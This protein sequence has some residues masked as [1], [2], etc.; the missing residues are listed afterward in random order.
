[1]AASPQAGSP[2]LRAALRSVS[3][4]PRQTYA[5]SPTR[6]AA[7][8]SFLLPRS[9]LAGAKAK[10]VILNLIDCLFFRSRC[11]SN[12]TEGYGLIK[13]ANKG[14]QANPIY[15]ILILLFV[16]NF[17][18]TPIFA[19]EVYTKN[20]KGNTLY[21]NGKF[22]DA[23][24]Q[25]DDALLISP[26]DTLLKMNRGSTLFRLGRLGEADTAYTE[27]LALK[28]K[29]KRADALYNLGN[30][31]FREGDQLMQSGDQNAGEKYKSALQNYIASLDLRPYDKNAKWNIELTQRRIKQQEQ[32][33]KNQNKNKNDQNKKDQN[34]QD[35]NKQDQNNKDKQDKD[36][37]KDKQDKNQDQN[38]KDQNKQ[39][40]DKNKEN[41]DQNQKQNDKQQQQPQPQ[42]QDKK[43]A[44][45]KKEA[46]R[47]IVQFADDADSLNKPPKKQGFG[48]KLH[49]PEKDW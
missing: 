39:D 45:K 5:S 40:Q 32:Q 47:I 30:I 25:Y 33:Q 34:K 49:K 15:S 16:T 14:P 28:N 9:V 19:D 27:A 41:Q 11:C 1:M 43:E 23:L 46:E 48:L 22:D 42:P 10:Q 26:T 29:Q 18:S 35:K 13:V 2:L 24:K 3:S 7:S 4:A 6:L 44:M 37:N 21:K 38:K 36:K 8:R 12:C 20:Q 17:L 31:Q